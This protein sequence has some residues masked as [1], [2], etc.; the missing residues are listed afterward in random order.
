MLAPLQVF[1]A[2]LYKCFNL[3]RF[4]SA[5]NFF[6]FTLSYNIGMGNKVGGLDIVQ[7]DYRH[8]D[9]CI[10]FLVRPIGRVMF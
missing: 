1:N 4:S 5:C 6:R 10:F 7:V 3:T 2:H 9:S 8:K